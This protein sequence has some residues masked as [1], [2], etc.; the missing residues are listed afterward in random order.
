MTREP[1]SVFITPEGDADVRELLR[2]IDRLCAEVG[3]LTTDAERLAVAG[4]A[5]RPWVGVGEGKRGNWCPQKVK[6]DLDSALRQHEE[7]E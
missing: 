5:A 3:R 1:F 2:E 4:E 7:R 6:D